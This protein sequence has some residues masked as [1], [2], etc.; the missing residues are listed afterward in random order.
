MR[1]Y[2]DEYY[3]LPDEQWL[4]PSPEEIKETVLKLHD[5]GE[6]N[7]QIVKY[8]QEWMYIF[9]DEEEYAWEMEVVENIIA[10]KPVINR[11]TKEEF[12]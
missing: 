3:E 6:S 4:S 5:N 9:T 8:L 1:R 7:D 12:N 10:G 11:W 2:I